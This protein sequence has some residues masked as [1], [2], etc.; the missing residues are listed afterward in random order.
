MKDIRQ[1]LSHP[2]T[3]GDISR[4]VTTFLDGRQS[5]RFFSKQTET[6][7]ARL[8]YALSRRT[9]ESTSLPPFILVF[10]FA[11][12]RWPAGLCT[13]QYIVQYIEHVGGNS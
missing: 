5:L 7:Y 1:S 10:I 4:G 3:V 9:V 12:H 13:I 11:R 2:P 6:L 8:E